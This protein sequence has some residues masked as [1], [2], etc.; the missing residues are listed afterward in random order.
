MFGFHTNNAVIGRKERKPYVIWR[1][2]DFLV[3]F[4]SFHLKVF[5]FLTEDKTNKTK[6]AYQQ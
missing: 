4:K 1:K 3:L 6:V 5:L 2:Y